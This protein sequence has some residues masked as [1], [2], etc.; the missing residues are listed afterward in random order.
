MSEIM[1]KL[2]PYSFGLQ[3]AAYQEFQRITAYTW[4]A[5]ARFGKL[6]MLQATGPGDDGLTLSGVVFPEHFG[7]TGQLDSLR[8]LAGLQQPQALI[9]GRGN[10]LGQWVI[11]SIDETGSIFAARGVARKQDFS[12]KL[13]RAA[14]DSAQGLIAPPAPMA[15]QS[16]PISPDLL[17]SAKNLA[18]TARNGGATMLG[19]LSE[20]LANVTGVAADLGEQASVALKAVRSGMN[21]AKTLQNAGSD[22]GALLAGVKSVAG[23]ASAMNGLVNVGGNISR[24]AGSASGALQ[25][26]GV[27]LGA[28]EANPAAVAALRGSMVAVNQLNVFA[29][30]V[31]STAQSI[32]GRL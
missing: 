8:A 22:A 30:S 6:N 23:I 7:G 2:G 11:E 29:V 13:K 26:A 14:D 21:L 24:A 16:F 17:S 4:A 1:M 20:S 31:R 18:S 10:M 3:T 27:E 32:I 28:I 19:T 5:Q 25:R 15:T 9:D 12:I